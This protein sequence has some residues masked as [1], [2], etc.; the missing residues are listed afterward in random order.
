MNRMFIGLV[1]AVALSFLPCRAGCAEIPEHLLYLG[2]LYDVTGSVRSLPVLTEAQLEKIIKVLSLRGGSLAFTVIDERADK[3]LA[4]LT[5]VRVSGRLDERARKKVKNDEAVTVFKDQVRPALLRA[6]DA[7][8]TDF[9]GP[10]AKINL[11]LTEPVIPKGARKALLIISDGIHT[12][13]KNKQVKPPTPDVSVLVIGIEEELA[14]KFFKDRVSLFES[15]DSAIEALT[16][17]D[18]GGL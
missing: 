9:Y 8:Q 13:P 17:I 15:I 16:T 3:P 1:L 14:R 18:K 7:S 12:F 2:I 4:R 6:R 11:F 5:L 10:V